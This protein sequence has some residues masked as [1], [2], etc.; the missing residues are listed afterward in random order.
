MSIE[1]EITRL[2]EA[3]QNLGAYLQEKGVSVPAYALLGDMVALLK[4][5]P[6][7][8]G[9]V[10]VEQFVRTVNPYG[11]ILFMEKMYD[12]RPINDRL[13]CA[14]AYI[15]YHQSLLALT[16]FK[17]QVFDSSMNINHRDT[18]L[19]FRIEYSG[20]RDGWWILDPS[21]AILSPGTEVKLVCVWD[22]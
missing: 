4:N 17:A 20:N 5:I 9:N 14:Y 22:K 1:A 15:E 13:I 2:V 12:M 19:V 18:G 6:L 16:P 21:L 7:P 3:K 11:E 10:R 8:E